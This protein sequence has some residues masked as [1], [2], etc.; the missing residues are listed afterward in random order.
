MKH[1]YVILFSL[2]IPASCVE[3]E[4]S[5]AEMVVLKHQAVKIGKLLPC[6]NPFMENPS[7]EMPS[8]K[9]LIVSFKGNK[10]A[11][12]MLSKAEFTFKGG[13]D[14]KTL[15]KSDYKLILFKEYGIYLAGDGAV[16]DLK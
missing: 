13:E 6:C 10:K 2:L 1:L 3:T 5:K 15:E 12:D 11:F 8:P 7:N 9:Q 14:P 16:R 4:P